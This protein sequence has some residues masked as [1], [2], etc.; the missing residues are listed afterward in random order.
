[1]GKKKKKKRNL[2]YSGD[3]D[4]TSLKAMG[5]QLNEYVNEIDKFVIKE[6]MSEES[7]QKAIKQVKKLV[8]KLKRGEVDKV[9]ESEE[10]YEKAIAAARDEKKYEQIDYDYY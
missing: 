4:K 9:F 3:Y 2:Q 8:K 10:M 6:E 1:M 5:N 7:Y